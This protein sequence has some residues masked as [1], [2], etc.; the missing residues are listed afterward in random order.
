VQMSR[1]R[2]EQLAWQHTTETQLSH[3]L[4]QPLAPAPVPAAPKSL[5]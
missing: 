2:G 5:R 1:W 4:G 3:L